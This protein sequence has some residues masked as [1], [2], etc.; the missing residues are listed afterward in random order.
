MDNT[1]ALFFIRKCLNNIK[2][3][4]GIVFIYVKCHYI[5]DILH[6]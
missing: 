1:I 5:C 3:Y 2:I 6:N 4:V